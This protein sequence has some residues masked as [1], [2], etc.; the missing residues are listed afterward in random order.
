MQVPRDRV[1]VPTKQGERRG[2]ECAQRDSEHAC[3]GNRRFHKNK[4]APTELANEITPQSIPHATPTLSPVSAC[5]QGRSRV[6]GE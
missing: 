4:S 6:R 2:N 5:A 1:F 3:K